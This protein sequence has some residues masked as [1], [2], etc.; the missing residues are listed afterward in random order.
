MRNPYKPKQITGCLDLMFLCLLA[1]VIILVA[2]ILV[3]K[4]LNGLL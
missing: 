4:I 2:L 1:W 3:P